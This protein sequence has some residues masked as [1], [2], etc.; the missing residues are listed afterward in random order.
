MKIN[1]ANPN[2]DRGAERKPATKLVK[3]FTETPDVDSNSNQRIE[4]HKLFDHFTE[5]VIKQHR[6]FVR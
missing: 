5:S 2:A 3:P 1:S 4:P 6:R